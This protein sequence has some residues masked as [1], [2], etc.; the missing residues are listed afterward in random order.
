TK[1]VRAWLYALVAVGIGRM[2][3]S[4]AQ[5]WA[6]ARRLVGKP[7]LIM[8]AGVVGAQVARRLEG[9]PEYGPAPTAFLD[10]D[11]RSIAEVG[12]RALPVLGTV[13]D[14]DETVSRTGVRNLIVAFSS[15][16]DERVS[17]LI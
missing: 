15:V 2:I 3:L 7:V 6:R 13:E 16:A 5:R 12:G 8:G 17:R 11:P 4:F 14:L 10:E 9:H 1:A